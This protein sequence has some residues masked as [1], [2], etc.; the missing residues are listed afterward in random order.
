[1]SFS[2][3]M[4]VYYKENP[5]YLKASLESVFSQTL[6]PDEVVLIEDGKLTPEL[7]D[8]IHLFQTRFSQ[9]KIYRFEENVMLGRA[10]QKGVELCEHELIARMDTDDIACDSRFEMQYEYMKN[11]PEIAVCGGMIQ[12]FNERGV[13]PHIKPMP[14]TWEEIKKYAKMRNPVNHMTVMFRK[15]E[16]LK[17]GNYR[18]F[19]FLEDYDL[20]VRMLENGAR[21]S[22]LSQV[23]VK[24]RVLEGMYERRG[25]ISY[26]RQYLKLR[27]I[28]HKQGMI[29]GLTYVKVLVVTIAIT[30]IPSGW[31]KRV[32]GKIL[33]RNA[34]G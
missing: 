11:N 7:Y 32:Y 2:V 26:C 34:N 23:L 28:Q 29:T 15:S 10:L 8:V 33:R 30:V 20:W 18:H 3:L 19:P 17:A 31:R 12:E 25:G 21:F 13:I 1:M 5:E 9:L 22:N 27:K 24:A 6:S 16:V 4:S 14:Q